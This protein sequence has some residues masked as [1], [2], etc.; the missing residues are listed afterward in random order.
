MI[1]QGQSP[2]VDKTWCYLTYIDRFSEDC[3]QDVPSKRKVFLCQS[4]DALFV[5]AR[6]LA[7]PLGIDEAATVG[8]S[9]CRTH[10]KRKGK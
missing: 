6:E 3:A 8:Q 4:A 7:E 5:S 1:R 9:P 10:H 2:N